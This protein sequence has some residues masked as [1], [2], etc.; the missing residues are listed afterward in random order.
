MILACIILAWLNNEFFCYYQ[1]QPIL[2][3]E[4]F[5]FKPVLYSN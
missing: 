5:M 3:G 1:D 4:P 2:E